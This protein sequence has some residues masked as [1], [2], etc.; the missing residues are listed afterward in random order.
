MDFMISAG[1]RI[2]V[3]NSTLQLPDEEIVPL[4]SGKHI[5]GN[6]RIQFPKKRLMSIIPNRNLYLMPGE[7]AMIRLPIHNDSDIIWMSEYCGVLPTLINNSGNF[8]Y[9]KYTNTNNKRVDINCNRRMAFITDQNTLPTTPGFVRKT[10]RL[11]KQWQVLV[12]EEKI[13]PAF[14]KIMETIHLCHY[15]ARPL[16]STHEKLATTVKSSFEALGNKL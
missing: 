1:I 4:L 10:S 12:G 14:K 7:H 9:L 16:F 13:L 2:D 3:G 15:R 5:C 8:K 11:Y 6:K